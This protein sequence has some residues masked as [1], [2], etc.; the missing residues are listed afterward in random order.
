MIALAGDIGGSRIKLAVVRDGSILARRI[1]PAKADL[2]WEHRLPALAE[3]WRALCHE[4][5]IELAAVDG[6]GLGFHSL[7]PPDLHLKRRDGERN[8]KETGT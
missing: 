6:L 8:E 4:A 1:E 3:T 5:R 2:P 7:R